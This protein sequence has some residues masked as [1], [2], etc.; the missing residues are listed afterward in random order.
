MTTENQELTRCAICGA[1]IRRDTTCE[2]CGAKLVGRS[3]PLDDLTRER[4]GRLS[5]HPDTQRWIRFDPDAARTAL[6]AAIG[7]MLGTPVAFLGIAVLVL[8]TMAYLMSSVFGVGDLNGAE[9][10]QR[11]RSG[12]YTLL[13]LLALAL[14]AIAAIVVLVRKALTRKSAVRTL[15][16]PVLIENC[17]EERRGLVTVVLMSGERVDLS[18]SADVLEK[19]KRGDMGI[20]VVTAQ[21]L[22]DFHL[23]A[24]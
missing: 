18:A 10:A 19:V 17:D 22:E 21:R 9:W 14:V 16:R 12:F 1:R 20:A 23:V 15:K 3:A 7:C 11:G 24:V 6:P 2:Y 13:G 5:R 8:G 4:F